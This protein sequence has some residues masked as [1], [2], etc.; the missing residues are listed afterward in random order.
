MSWGKSAVEMALA[1]MSATGV[2]KGNQG[3]NTAL[4]GMVN[5]NATLPA[6]P[7]STKN[8]TEKKPF[9]F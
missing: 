9:G 8:E 7:T 4:S 3:E 6:K 5:F 1:R 2:F